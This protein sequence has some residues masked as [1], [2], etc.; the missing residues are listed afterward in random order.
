[1]SLCENFL[2]SCCYP[3]F[4]GQVNI[5]PNL[6][7]IAKFSQNCLFV[8]LKN[9]KRAGS[10][11]D[12]HIVKAG[13]GKAGTWKISR[14]KQPHHNIINSLFILGIRLG[15]NKYHSFIMHVTARLPI[16]IG[17][18]ENQ[19]VHFNYICYFSTNIV[20]KNTFC[21]KQRC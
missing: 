15:Q 5:C 1:M 10:Y 20:Y 16:N 18:P 14:L 21:S 4:C 12:V 7:Q 19:M 9:L 13:D 8:R 11:Q 6:A 17:L 3:L 2:L